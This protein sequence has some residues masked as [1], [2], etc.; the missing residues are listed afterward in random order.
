MWNECSLL[1]EAGSLPPP[2]CFMNFSFATRLGACEMLGCKWK[3]FSPQNG[4]KPDFDVQG[5]HHLVLCGVS[6]LCAMFIRLSELWLLVQ[7]IERAMVSLCLSLVICTHL[8]QKAKWDLRTSQCESYKRKT[9]RG[10]HFLTSKIALLFEN[11]HNSCRHLRIYRESCLQ[12]QQASN[13]CLIAS[14]QHLANF[15]TTLIYSVTMGS[16]VAAIRREIFI[17]PD[18]CQRLP[19]GCRSYRAVEVH[20]DL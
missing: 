5:S 2:A 19:P 9:A 14:I 16:L 15:P 20:I 10:S 6:S 18:W 7:H 13:L 4:E 3:P 17:F 11:T 1:C 8:Q 12:R